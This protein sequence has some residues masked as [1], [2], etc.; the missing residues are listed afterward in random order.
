VNREAAIE[1]GARVLAGLEEG[2][3]W[4]TNESLGGSAT[5]TRDDE[6][7]HALRSE[8]AAVIDA[9]VPAIQAQALRDAAALIYSDERALGPHNHP[10]SV[11]S[12]LRAR[13]D[14]IEGG[15]QQQGG[16]SE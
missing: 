16:T 9:V 5:G 7:R 15:E 2:Q 3:D 10:F 12:W 14:R 8:A 11:A 13:A 1:A 6:Y 4:P